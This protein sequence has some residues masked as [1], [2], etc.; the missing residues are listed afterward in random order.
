MDILKYIASGVLEEYCLGLLSEEDEA[1]LIQMTIL[2]PEIKEELTAVESAMEKIAVSNAIEPA[3]GVKQRILAA[4]GF[5]GTETIAN[6]DQ[7]PTISANT[8]RQAWFNTLKHLIPD[9]PSEDFSCEVFRSDD[10]IRQMLVITKIDVKEE[11]HSDYLESFF[12]LEGRCECTVGNN[13]YT[14]GTGDFLEIPLHLKHNI[15]LLSPYV[16]AIL[17][18]EYV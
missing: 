11:Q 18:Y 12:I 10:H 9:E 16:M 3:P 2:Y 5:D 15:K 13:V 4:L 7:L 1:Y 8:D 17:Q 14:L 6:L